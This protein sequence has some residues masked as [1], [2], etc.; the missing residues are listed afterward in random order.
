MKGSQGRFATP[1][2]ILIGQISCECNVT[3]FANLL[4]YIFHCPLNITSVSF[5]MKKQMSIISLQRDFL[6]VFPSLCS[7][8]LM[9]IV[10]HLALHYFQIDFLSILSAV[11]TKANK[12]RQHLM[13]RGKVNCP[14]LPKYK[15]KQILPHS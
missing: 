5:K 13:N 12:Q 8:S 7:S 2:C 11:K 4:I 15:A 14:Y 6:C 1:A 3:R 9:I 10:L